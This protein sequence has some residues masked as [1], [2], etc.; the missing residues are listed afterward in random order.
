MTRSLNS[1]GNSSLDWRDQAEPAQLIRQLSRE[2]RTQSTPCGNEAALKKFMAGIDGNIEKQKGGG[3][4]SV[5]FGLK[6]LIAEVAFLRQAG[7]ILLQMIV[8]RGV[9]LHVHSLSAFILSS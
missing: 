1:K 5:S 4:A 2:L 8:I 3:D 7:M 6:F 9:P